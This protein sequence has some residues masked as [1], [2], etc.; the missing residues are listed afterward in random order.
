M[1]HCPFCACDGIRSTMVDM[2][3]TRITLVG[4]E[5]VRVASVVNAMCLRCRTPFGPFDLAANHGIIAACGV[6]MTLDFFSTCFYDLC[7]SGVAVGKTAGRLI[8]QAM[9]AQHTASW[10]HTGRTREVDR[11][12][13]NRTCPGSA[14]R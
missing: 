6:G 4:L 7:K 11:T 8:R 10:Q 3:E 5:F 12:R 2:P 1:T 13:L 9:R 14:P